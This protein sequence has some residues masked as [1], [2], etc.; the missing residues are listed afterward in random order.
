M[1]KIIEAKSDLKNNKVYIISSILLF[2]FIISI[3]YHYILGYYLQ[4]GYPLNTFLFR[5]LAN[6]SDFYQ[7]YDITAQ[8]NNSTGD[9]IAY[10]PF[11]HLLLSIITY[12]PASIAFK[13]M[14]FTFIGILYLQLQFFVADKISIKA[15]KYQ[16]ILIIGLLTYPT[17]ISMDRGNI[18]VIIYSFIALFFY[19]YYFKKSRWLAIIFLAFAIGMKIYAAV[20]LV[21]LFGDK[22]YREI[23]YTL[24]LVFLLTSFGYVVMILAS[25][26]TLIEVIKVVPDSTNQYLFYYAFNFQGLTHSHSLWNIVDLYKLIY[27]PALD[28]KSVFKLYTLF[29]LMVFVLSALYVVFIEEELWKKIALMLISMIVLPYASGDYT[30]IYIY[31]PLTFFLLAK[32]KS[33]NDLAY[34]LFFCLLLVPLN[35]IYFDFPVSKYPYLHGDISYSVLIYPVLL[36]LFM[37]KIMLDGLLV[38]FP[39]K[40]RKSK[41]SIVT[42]SSEV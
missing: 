26:K 1:T 17:L 2:A 34:I 9:Y 3:S 31:F 21:L 25:G 36:I 8:F 24:L 15:L 35:Y 40:A 29:S 30:L 11:T 22:K 28:L 37:V 32:E 14:V 4:S 33:K 42:S 41:P 6:F 7:V 18:E 5:P 27:N 12:I 23:A 38:K 16:I 10:F 20:L 39:L 19:F 13:L